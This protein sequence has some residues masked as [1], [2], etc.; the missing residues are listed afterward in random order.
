M[1]FFK[2]AS[3]FGLFAIAIAAGLSVS[4]R[5]F[6]D[7]GPGV[8]TFTI[9]G[10]NCLN[11]T[12]PF[13]EAQAEA[14]TIAVPLVP[15]CGAE[16]KTIG[17][18]PGITAYNTIGLG[19]RAGLPLTYT[20]PGWVVDND[21]AIVDNSIS[22]DII[23][24]ID[25][26]CDSTVDAFASPGGTGSTGE[27]YREQTTAWSTT[28]GPP[29][30]TINGK[31][32][33]GF[34]DE[35]FLDT[36]IPSTS[37]YDKIVRFRA[38]ATTVWIG[39]DGGISNQLGTITPINLITMHPQFSP[40]GTQVSLALLGGAPSPPGTQL[41]CLDTPQASITHTDGAYTAN[42]AA[43]GL[44]ARWTAIISAGDPHTGDAHAK[45][46]TN[47]KAIGISFTDADGD[48]LSPTSNAGASATD[49]A[50][51]DPDQDDDGLLDGVEVA[52][53]TS[54]TDSDSDNDG[55]S[56]WEEML[57][58]NQFLTDPTDTQSVLPGDTDGDGDADGG[59]CLDAGVDG[60]PDSPDS[61]GDG[62][63]GDLH[64]TNFDTSGDGSSHVISG[65]QLVECAG[66]D[67]TEGDNCGTVS[68]GTQDNFDGAM[69][70]GDRLGDACDGDD[71]QDGVNDKLDG[72]VQPMYFD[73]LAAPVGT[74]GGASRCHKDIRPLKN[75]NSASNATPI[76]VGVTGHGYSN[77]DS[78][79][80]TGVLG[81]TAANGTFV[82]SAVGANTF[83]LN[84][85]AGNG[86]YISGDA[87]KAQ[88]QAD[89][90]EIGASLGALDPDSDGDGYLDGAECALGTN[91]AS[92]AS[93]PG[94]PGAN[95]ND[96]DG[97]LP[98]VERFYRTGTF[99]GTANEDV[100]GD[101][102]AGCST[103]TPTICGTEDVD[104]DGDG[105]KDRMEATI[106]GTS[107]FSVD[108]DNDGIN[109]PN[110]TFPG[111]ECGLIAYGNAHVKEFSVTRMGFEDLTVPWWDGGPTECGVTWRG[112]VDGDGDGLVDTGEPTGAN[113][114]GVITRSPDLDVTFDDDLDGN[115]TA[116]TL[117]GNDPD[118]SPG[119]DDLGGDNGTATDSDGDGQIDGA[120]C[121]PPNGG[122]ATN[123]NLNTSR[124]TLVQCGP[125]ASAD[126]DGDGLL[127]R[128]ENCKWGTNPAVADTDG[129]GVGDC[130]EVLDV[131]GNKSV[132]T[133]GDFLAIAN[134]HFKSGTTGKDGVY[135]LD[136]NNSV[137]STGDFLAS[138]ARIFGTGGQ[139][140]L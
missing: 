96:R 22:G 124:L 57:G 129:D 126:T 26:F 33:Q 20:G 24:F 94:F 69:P 121:N 106:L 127:D 92:L 71:D 48:C 101:G 86:V 112:F 16:T 34:A 134:V 63:L 79:T 50:D 23:S 73:A 137:Q 80:I 18:S 14:G 44:Y 12:L 131:D 76:V 70:N 82:I 99:S 38:D 128:W 138:A 88:K 41:L 17:S 118:G 95:D 74:T 110:E 6:A 66:G 87:D 40:A 30:V 68:N 104:S 58:P 139:P 56:D 51:G 7:H 111:S 102:P 109:D 61:N 8:Q 1:R 13:T 125:S 115:T 53:G 2:L 42:P 83:T 78:V 25:L 81:N 85:S 120:E 29:D 113:C 140:C 98:D 117:G 135:D 47:C 39:G 100:D 91:P 136:G 114:A 49:A 3:V 5:S 43:N 122:A 27:D 4:E 59:F 21:A 37:V 52:W 9:D 133:T 28:S 123:P 62:T 31:N 132:Q 116:G 10:G 64:S 105:L 90:P 75:V 107:P 67:T 45:V 89:L 19:T 93:V 97:L 130:K 32:V 84:G 77:G 46:I 65:A 60:I 11:D 15:V 119:G 36:A 72:G 108:S 103:A 55:R 54:P 35:T